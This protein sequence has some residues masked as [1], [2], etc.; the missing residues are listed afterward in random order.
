MCNIN[1]ALQRLVYHPD[2]DFNSE[3]GANET[4]M[5]TIYQFP[6]ETSRETKSIAWLVKGQND[7]PVVNLLASGNG[8]NKLTVITPALPPD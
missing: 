4:L 2:A 7:L 3:F 8:K 1:G 5:A 6:D